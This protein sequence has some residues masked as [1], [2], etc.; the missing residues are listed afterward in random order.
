[1]IKLYGHSQSPYSQRVVL[2]LREL[3][4]EYQYIPIDFEQGEHQSEEFQLLNPFG[5]VPCLKWDGAVISESLAICRYIVAKVGAANLYPTNILA[6][7]Q[8]DQ[9]IDYT[10]IHLGLALTNLAWHRYWCPLFRIPTDK[11]HAEK[12]EKRITKE[13]PI[14][15]RKLAGHSFFLSDT[16]K[17]CDFSFF[18]QLWVHDKAEISLEAYPR[19]LNWKMTMAQRDTWKSILTQ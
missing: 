3:Q 6:R 13:L 2:I 4:L 10:N 15:E 7:A 19:V 12:L 14:I 11:A 18:P 8:S 16:P 17:L 9:W 5:R 1:M